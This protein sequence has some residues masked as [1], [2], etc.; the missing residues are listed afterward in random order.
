MLRVDMY[1]GMPLENI[2]ALMDAL[3]KYSLYY[4]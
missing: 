1:Y 3:E 4:S 2:E